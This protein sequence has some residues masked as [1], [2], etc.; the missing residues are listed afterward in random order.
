M[1]FFKKT[2]QLSQKSPKEC[3]EDFIREYNCNVKHT[4]KDHVFFDFQGGH[5]VAEVDSSKWTAIVYPGIITLPVGKLDIVRHACNNSNSGSFFRFVYG[6]N[7]AQTEVSVDIRFTVT[8]ALPSEFADYLGGCMYVQRGFCQAIEESRETDENTMLKNRELFLMRQQELSCRHSGPES[9]RFDADHPLKLDTIL[10]SVGITDAIY[11]RL[12]VS[13]DGECRVITDGGEIHDFNMPATLLFDNDVPDSPFDNEMATAV[14]KYYLVDDDE[15]HYLSIVA[16]AQGHDGGSHYIRLMVSRL[17]KP[18]SR[19]HSLDARYCQFLVVIDNVSPEK[20]LQE[21]NYM[22]GEA[23]IKARDG[24]KLTDEEELLLNLNNADSSYDTY[25]GN[26]Y[27]LQG[28]YYE[29]L[30]HY[31]NTFNANFHDYYKMSGAKYDAML[32]IC[33]RIGFCYNELKNF[34]EAFYYLNILNGSHVIAHVA[35]Y[36][37]VLAN[38]SDVRSIIVI[39]H[40]LASLRDSYSVEN[41]EDAVPD[42]IVEFSNFLHRRLGYSMIEF[43]QLEEAREIF[44]KL[45]NEPDSKDYAENELKVID[46]RMRIM[47]S[48]KKDEN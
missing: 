48:A 40:I 31:L 44:T 28:R 5:F 3:F 33:Y 17:A 13:V 35:E 37:N 30:Q 29:A 42:H 1:K 19:N 41:E 46:A 2:Q 4:D 39:K 18:L 14:L 8:R 10:R 11:R 26:K 22:L 38:G 9:N 47:K 43:N 27:F 23:E 34:H 36:V 7:D 21:F 32:D 24:G 15:P 25:W 20:K 6:L 12:E 16:V 45:L